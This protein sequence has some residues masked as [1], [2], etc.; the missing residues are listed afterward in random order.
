MTKKIHLLYFA[1]FRQLTNKDKE[2]IET[3]AISPKEIYKELQFIY[4]F[5]FPE[6]FFKVAINEEYVSLDCELCD[7]DTLVFIPPVAGG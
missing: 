6:N 2:T 1:Q 4:G 7:G 3:K 5:N